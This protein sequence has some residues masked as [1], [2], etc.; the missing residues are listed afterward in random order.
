MASRAFLISLT[1]ISGESIPI[2]SNGAMPAAPDS[3]G[4]FFLNAS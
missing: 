2:G 1:R 3:P 4:P